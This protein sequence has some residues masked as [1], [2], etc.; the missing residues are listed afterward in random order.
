MSASIE[1]GTLTP[2]C[3]TE[4]PPPC[5]IFYLTE[6]CRFGDKCS[7]AHDYLLKPEH[8]EEMRENAKKSACPAMNRGTPTDSCAGEPSPDAFVRT[9]RRNLHVRR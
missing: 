8:Q 7:F 1:R 6:Y 2:I 3:A 4:D 9:C 5:N